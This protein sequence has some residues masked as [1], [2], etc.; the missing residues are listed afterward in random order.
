MMVWFFV[1]ALFII[2]FVKKDMIK[3]LLKS[4]GVQNSDDTVFA[5]QLT[6]FSIVMFITFIY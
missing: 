2:S 3:E 5:I 6:F 1:L 4:L